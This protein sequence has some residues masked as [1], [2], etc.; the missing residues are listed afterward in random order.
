MANQVGGVWYANQT[1]CHSYLVG[2]R[3]LCS[4]RLPLVGTNLLSSGKIVLKHTITNGHGVY[5]Y[6]DF[7]QSLV[8][9]VSTIQSDVLPD[10]LPTG[11][12]WGRGTLNERTNSIV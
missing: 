1:T 3:I 10:V 4:I 7:I 5:E 6:I 12:L 11:C 2:L 8:D 9:N